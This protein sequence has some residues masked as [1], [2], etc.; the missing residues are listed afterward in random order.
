M[1]DRG[2]SV[3]CYDRKCAIRREIARVTIVLNARLATREIAGTPRDRA[4]SYAR[5]CSAIPARAAL[6]FSLFPSVVYRR[7][8]SGRSEGD[9]N[10]TTGENDEAKMDHSNTN[11][12]GA[13][14]RA[15]DVRRAY[16]ARSLA[17]RKRI[18][19]SRTH[20]PSSSFRS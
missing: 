19:K 5:K 12:T 9:I 17:R 14:E 10:R 16:D 8:L 20:L 3:V 4:A 15:R 18:V 6:S 13:S 2:S 1:A 7:L 11:A